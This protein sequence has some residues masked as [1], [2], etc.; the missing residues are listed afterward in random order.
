M[1]LDTMTLRP[2]FAP[3]LDQ[4]DR[5]PPRQRIHARQR[6]VE[7]QQFGIVRQRLRHLHALAHPFAVGAD[8]LVGRIGEID[9]LERPPRGLVGLL[10]VDAVEA[11]RARSTHSSPV[12][13]S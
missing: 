3:F 8:L 4:P 10:L 13:R 11:R 1:W 9:Q 12:I 5:L 6:L 2:A 7:N